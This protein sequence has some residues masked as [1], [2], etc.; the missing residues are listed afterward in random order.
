MVYP[1]F[2]FG[3]A[4]DATGMV[5]IFVDNKFYM[6]KTVAEFINEA[7][8]GFPRYEPLE[9]YYLYLENLGYGSH[10]YKVIYSGDEKYSL[11]KPIEGVFNVTYEFDVIEL[12]NDHNENYNIGDPVKFGIFVS[13]DVKKITVNYNGKS[14]DV[15]PTSN[16][17]Y[18]AIVTISDLKSGENNITFTCHVDN[19]PSKSIIQTVH[20]NPVENP[21]NGAD[22]NII[23][24]KSRPEITA[25][26][27]K[28]IYSAGTKY[29]S[30]V[31]DN[32][33][34]AGNTKVTF[35]INGK[36]F[37]TVTTNAKGVA[38]IKI[39][40]KP[41]T[42]KITT[43]A[44]DKSVTYKLTVKHILNLK[45][46]NVKRSAKKLVIT[47]GLAK[48]N[49][50]YL[51]GKKITL[52]FNGKKYIA[53]TNKKGVVKFTINKKMLKKLKA[54]KK[55]KYQATYLKDT[56]SYFVKIKK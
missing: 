19:C 51:K 15:I 13:D 3:F 33:K 27:L 8:N 6:N 36:V 45:K 50:K 43:K 14:V 37:K 4:K 54:G 26:N 18:D 21:Q 46:V 12:D 2:T 16:D 9:V 42:Y 31:Y 49:G 53:K 35:L 7:E 23:V 56:V 22:A 24:E 28:V 52:K 5:Q 10:T 38:T 48:I 30:T 40:Q 47:A 41:G 20:V 55:V 44:L 29:K 39:T 1:R 25:T 32:G 11:E 34:A 17:Y